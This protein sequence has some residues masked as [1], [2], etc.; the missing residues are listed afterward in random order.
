MRSFCEPIL[1]RIPLA[2]EITVY[3]DDQSRRRARPVRNPDTR[4]KVAQADRGANV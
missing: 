3:H 2:R 1:I 4:L